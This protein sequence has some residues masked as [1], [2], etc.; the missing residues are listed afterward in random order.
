MYLS[1]GSPTK[2]KKCVTP[3]MVYRICEFYSLKERFLNFVTVYR[4]S[5]MSIL[6][7]LEQ[8]FQTISPSL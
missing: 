7:E 4:Q 5:I 8:K 6:R 2:V 1:N 3:S